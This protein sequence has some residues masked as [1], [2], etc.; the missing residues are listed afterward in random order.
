VIRIAVSLTA[1]TAIIVLAICFG[2]RCSS[3]IDRV[4]GGMLVGGCAGNNIVGAAT[5]I[6]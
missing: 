2:L 4:I 3:S 5:D 1:V 6:D